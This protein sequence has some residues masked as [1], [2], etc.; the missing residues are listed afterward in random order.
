MDLSKGVAEGTSL[1]NCMRKIAEEH[2]IALYNSRNHLHNS[3]ERLD[4]LVRRF[5]LLC[6]Q[7]PVRSIDSLRD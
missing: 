2:L 1:S 5:I 4:C 3:H 6:R 7:D